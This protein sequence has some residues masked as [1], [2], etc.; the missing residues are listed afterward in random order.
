LGNA[1]IWRPVDF[2]FDFATSNLAAGGMAVTGQSANY[3]WRA[4]NRQSS[5][6]FALDN[7]SVAEISGIELF[8]PY[9]GNKRQKFLYVTPVIDGKEAESIRI[10]ELM[11]PGAIP[12]RRDVLAESG[13][14]FGHACTNLGK[15]LL[16]G[17]MPEEATPK[18]G[19]GETLSLKVY[20]ALTTDGGTSLTQPM[21]ARVWMLQVKG[22]EKLRSLLEHFHGSN[23]QGATGLYSGGQLDCGF[24]IGDLENV[25]TMPPKPFEKK[26]GA[27]GGF[28]LGDWTRVHGGNDCDKPKVQ[29]FITYAQNMA[30]S[31]GNSWLQFTQDGQRVGADW[32]VL[33][34]N[35]DKRDAIKVTHIGVKSH[36]NLKYVRLARSGRA[37][38]YI[39]EVMLGSNP[40]EMPA[41]RYI[42]HETHGPA[43]LPR[44]FL[45]WNDQGGVEV[46]DNGT[47]IPAW[48]ASN[49]G[50]MV[51]LYGKKYELP[52]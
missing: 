19:P 3:Y 17:G 7:E 13:F 11:A 48:S 43:K 20:G 26:V 22:E 30:A 12:G 21:R 47:S 14:R 41:G 35:L 5:S 49:E 40:L 28:R 32:Q 45:L 27:S 36:K 8:G 46:L 29:N 1:Y 31:V 9:D 51:A 38:D 10:N 42:E 4:D 16:A 2:V 39:H 23:K 50:V 25:E 34:Y 37:I 33:S 18:I 6:A 15:P 52:E 24:T 44:S